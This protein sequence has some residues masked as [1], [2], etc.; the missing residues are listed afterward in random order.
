MSSKADCVI[1]RDGDAL[2]D[3]VD[4]A[5]WRGALRFRVADNLLNGQ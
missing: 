5:D 2:P 4:Y 1:K 3:W